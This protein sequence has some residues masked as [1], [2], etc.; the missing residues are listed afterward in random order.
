MFCRICGQNLADGAKFCTGCGNPVAAETPNPAPEQSAA[1]PVE[2]PV[3]QPQPTIE[4]A[5]QP[6]YQAPTPQAN[7][8]PAPKAPLH[9]NPSIAA[10]KKALSSPLMLVATIVYSLMVLF[11]S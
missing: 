5:P 8:A 4:P 11:V 7:F 9:S 3:P 6:A 2:T 1:A 10:L